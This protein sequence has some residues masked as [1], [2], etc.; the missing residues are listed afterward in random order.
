VESLQVDETFC[1]NSASFQSLV[2][3]TCTSANFVRLLRRLPRLVSFKTGILENICS[4]DPYDFKTTFVHKNLAQ[5]KII[6]FDMG[7]RFLPET[8]DEQDAN[9]D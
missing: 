2:L 6:L 7:L 4:I 1:G 8:V 9:Q 3:N 5:L